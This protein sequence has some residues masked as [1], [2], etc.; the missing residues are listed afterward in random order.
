LKF[1]GPFLILLFILMVNVISAAGKSKL[2]DH[3]STYFIHA[4]T[5]IK[6]DTVKDRKLLKG[7]KNS[8]Q[9]GVPANSKG[10]NDTTKKKDG[11]QS[12]VKAHAEDSTRVDNVHDILYLYGKARVTYE[13]FELDA[14]YIMVDR[15]NHI[16]YASGSIDPITKRYIGRPISKQKND[17]PIICDSLR[18]NYETKK[19][20]LY[21][22]Y[23]DQDGDYITNG[24]IKKLNDDETAVKN[25]LFTTCDLPYPDTHFGIVITKGIIEKKRIV[26]G[27]AYLEIE[28]VPLPL[29]I[30]FGFFPKPDQKSSGVIIPT[31]GEDAQ[32]GFYLRNFGY[33]L[34]L[35]DYMDLTSQGTLYSKGS[36]EINEAFR[37]LNRYE[38]QGNLILNYGSHNYGLPGDPPKKDFNIQWS[39]AQNP[40]SNPGTTFSASVNAGTSSF[41]RNNP[42]TTGYNLQALTQNNLTSSISYTRTWAGTPF[43]FSADLR[44]SQ[45]LTAK[46]IT[47]ELPTFNFNMSTISPFD[48][49]DRIGEQKWYQKITVGYSLQGTNKITN[50]PESELF[51]KTTLTKRLQNGFEHRIPVGFNLNLFKYFQFSTSANY[52][53]LW[54]F[55]STRQRFARGSISGMDSLVTDTLG[56][57]KR[58]GYYNLGASLSTKV[59]ST[60]QFKSGKI[61]AIRHVMT[62]A[63]SFNYQPDF[64]DP[65]FGYYRTAVSNATVPYPVTYQKYSIFQQGVYGGPPTGKSAGVGFTLDNTI[66]AKIKPKSTDTTTKDKKISLIDGLSFATFYNFA[67]DSFQLSPITFSGHTALFNKKLNINF[68]GTFNPYITKVFDSVSNGQLQ[69]NYRLINRFAW[70]DGKF[71]ELTS[72]NISASASFNSTTIKPQNKSQ[73]PALGTSIQNMTPEQRQKLAF[74]NSDPS[75][76]VDFNVPWNVSL[77]YSFNY[78]NNYTSTSVTNTIMI[79]GDLNLTPKW[80]IQYQTNYDLRAGR[81]S[82]ATSFSIYRDLHCWDLSMQWLPFGYYKSYNVTLKVKSTILQDLKLTKRSDY[83]NNQYFTP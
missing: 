7:K 50:V 44:H 8:N 41:Y 19:G 47:L 83:T 68:G 39:H 49:K 57:F 27:P 82:S 81:L 5:I 66:E 32:L 29:V 52:T 70:Q 23:T 28:G 62:P 38:Y 16:M 60:F 54:Y 64:S 71:P 40:N 3:P 15:K 25:I 46:T 79:S 18:F 80:K 36:Y 20:K 21:N 42:A 65:S 75:A 45:D 55:Q 43:N 77:N 26:S 76:Y 4:D 24:Q 51:Q 74:I 30:P 10:Q 61:K 73:P 37:Y 14:D 31:F 78:G 9:K 35:N 56:G 2:H 58:A 63:L 12:E 72:I 67:A 33:Y 6:L 69:R 22:P 53:E 13:D 11:L 59:Y 48:S 17:K 1:T 34:A